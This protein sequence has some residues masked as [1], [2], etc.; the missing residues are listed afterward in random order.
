M[1][2]Q[3]EDSLSGIFSTV[4]DQSKRAQ[5]GFLRDSASGLKQFAQGR[6]IRTF[7]DSACV[8]FRY[9]KDVRRRLRI[10]VSNRHEMIAF[11]DNGCRNLPGNYLAK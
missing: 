2:M 5:A 1:D 8:L 11:F 10:Y 9:Y 4:Y 7:V 3:V 6:R